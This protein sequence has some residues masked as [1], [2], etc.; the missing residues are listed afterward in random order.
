VDTDQ[1]TVHFRAPCPG[2]PARVAE[3]DSLLA[4]ALP[5]EQDDFDLCLIELVPMLGRIVDIDL[6]PRPASCLLAEPLHDSLLSVRTQ[7]IHDQVECV[8]CGI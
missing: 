4:R 7:V 5:V 6:L 8:S 1:I 2:F 3:R